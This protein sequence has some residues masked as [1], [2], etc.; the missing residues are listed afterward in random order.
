MASL[1]DPWLFRGYPED[2]VSLGISQH[3]RSSTVWRLAR[4]SPDLAGHRTRFRDMAIR[5]SL[6]LALT[7]AFLAGPWAAD[8]LESR[9][10]TIFR[11]D[12]PRQWLASLISRILTDFPA[13]G[14]LPTERRL[15]LFV[16]SKTRIARHER[17]PGATRLVRHL[18]DW[19]RLMQP[20]AGVAATWTVPQIVSMAELAEWLQVTTGELGWFA[21]VANWSSTTNR[22]ALRHYRYRWLKKSSGGVRLLETPKPRLMQMQ[23]RI[24]D[25][26]LNKIPAHSAAHAFRAGHSV[27][28]LCKMS[29]PSLA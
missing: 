12:R 1:V 20:A 9:A 22:E 5:E 21:N 6:V 10:R 19:P 18:P 29:I 3:E 16:R 14:P 24:L 15:R 28:P 11:E 13:S 26:I 7:R 27:S 17:E 23:R 2:F 8:E 25:G 4:A